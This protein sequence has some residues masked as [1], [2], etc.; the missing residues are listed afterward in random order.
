MFS[1]GRHAIPA[2]LER[3]FNDDVR[4]E[5]I[6]VMDV[7]ELLETSGHP[8]RASFWIVSNFW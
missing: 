4:T 1:D 3:Q 7:V 5:I 2:K 6:D 8:A